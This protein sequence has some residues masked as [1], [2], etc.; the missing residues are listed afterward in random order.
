MVNE[1]MD[2]STKESTSGNYEDTTKLQ[3]I[4]EKV[5]DISTKYPEIFEE[6]T[7]PT[8]VTKPKYIKE[9]STTQSGDEDTPIICYDKSP[10][11]II[12]TTLSEETV[13]PTSLIEFDS[14][15]NADKRK[16]KFMHEEKTTLSGETYMP[17]IYSH[18]SEGSTNYVDT[19]TFSGIVSG[20]TIEDTIEDVE[21][22]D[23][24]DTVETTTI[25]DEL[26]KVTS[27]T[28]QEHNGKLYYNNHAF[29]C[30]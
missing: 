29:K 7:L 9:E 5:S 13:T 25:Q 6:S 30:I 23:L 26:N 12:S 10:T 8:D 1:R 4:H 28:E 17:I 22:I 15:K 24:R 19:T 18:T 27:T 20:S 21:G 14:T 16:P 3:H 2:S 11:S